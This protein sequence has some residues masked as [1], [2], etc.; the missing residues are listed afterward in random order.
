MLRNGFGGRHGNKSTRSTGKIRVADKSSNFLNLVKHIGGDELLFCVDALSINDVA[1]DAAVTNWNDAWGVWNT[2]FTEGTNKPALGVY[3]GKRALSFDG[4]ND[5]MASNAAVSQLNG[6][7]KLSIVYF[8]KNDRTADAFGFVLEM[9]TNYYASNAFVMGQNANNA[10]YSVYNGLHKDSTY[11]IGGIVGN[12]AY[13]DANL[14]LV[15]GAVF[16]RD[17]PGAGVNKSV[18]PY[19]N[20]APTPDASIYSDGYEVNMTTAFASNKTFY[21]GKRNSDN[22]GHFKGSI[23]CMV[24]IMRD[25]TTGEMS[26]LSAAMLDRWNVGN[27]AALKQELINVN[28]PTVYNLLCPN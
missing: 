27:G 18:K 8:L 12:D 5:F 6:K 7:K 10:A 20:G 19:I 22:S 4:S 16:D 17:S 15:Y 9:D 3:N 11:N 24:A 1:T 13:V 23:G 28:P 21:L 26:R 25:L 2:Y 14:P